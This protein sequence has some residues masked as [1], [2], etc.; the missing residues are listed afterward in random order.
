MPILLLFKL[1]NKD[2][3]NNDDEETRVYSVFTCV[4]CK[5]R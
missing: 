4:H 1:R 2:D 5:R 3:N